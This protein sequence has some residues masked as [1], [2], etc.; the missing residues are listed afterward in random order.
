[1]SDTRLA[2]LAGRTPATPNTG[3][4]CNPVYDGYFADPFVFQ[5]GDSYYAV[6]TAGTERGIF[7]MLKS[8]DLVHWELLGP[9]LEQPD[10]GLGTDFWAPEIALEGGRFY[11]Y[12][13]VGFRDR[14]HRLRV[15]VADRPQGPYVDLCIDLVDPNRV[16]FAID[17]S[18]F[19][20][21]AGDRYLFYAR[22]VVSSEHGARPGTVIVVDRM[23]SMTKLKGEER[24]IIRATR[25]WQRFM[26]DRPIYGGVYDWHTLEGPCAAYHD[27]NYYCFYSGGRWENASY[28]VDF[29]VADN[30]MGPWT[31]D[32][33]EKP[34]V[35]G[36]VADAVIGPGHN[37]IVKGPDGESDYIVY[38]AWDTEMK[39]RRMC[40]DRLGWTGDGPKC[41][42]PTWTY[43]PI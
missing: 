40:I 10:P 25:D 4:Y 16:G 33:G 24:L 30:V 28:G 12:Y 18:P 43:Q 26:R 17:A 19:V 31:A 3:G 22:D 11:M 8:P 15:A 36:S 41:L 39:A 7:P 35:L 5:S 32:A 21:A 14:N 1:M 13:S 2:G 23:E 9:S 42:G 20:D 37:S 27:G 38:H 29:A 34:R 6:G